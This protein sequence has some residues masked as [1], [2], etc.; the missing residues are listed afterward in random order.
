MPKFRILFSEESCLSFSPVIPIILCPK[1]PVFFARFVIFI[2]FFIFVSGVWK[3]ALLRTPQLID[4]TVLA[5]IFL[6]YCSNI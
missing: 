6:H 4:S 2:F 5:N 3:A 1:S